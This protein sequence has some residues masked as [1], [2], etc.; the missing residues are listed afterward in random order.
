MSTDTPAPFGVRRIDSNVVVSIHGTENR[1]HLRVHSDRSSC[2]ESIGASDPG[3]GQ[4]PFVG[5]AY[6]A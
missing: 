5:A 6:V 2:Q 1:L 4:T 3:H